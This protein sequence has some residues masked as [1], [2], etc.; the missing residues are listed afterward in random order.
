MLV[1]FELLLNDD[2]WCFMS[3][4]A[5]EK[6]REQDVSTQQWENKEKK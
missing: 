5:Q 1:R 3:P 6:K 2:L 4:E